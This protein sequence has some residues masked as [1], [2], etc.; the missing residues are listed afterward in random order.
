[1]TIRLLK[2]AAF[3][4]VA[5]AAMAP[6]VDDK[7]PTPE[8]L[9]KNAFGASFAGLTKGSAEMRMV[10]T[11]GNTV[12]DRTISFK[13]MREGKLLRYLVTFDSPPDERGTA[14][15]VREK[16]KDFPEQYIWLPATKTLTQAT[17]G[18]A[19]G[20]FFGSDFINADLEP[21]PEGKNDKV[22]LTRL[23][24]R[25]VGQ[26]IEVSYLEAGQKKV[27][28]I[29]SDQK[30]YVLRVAISDPQSPYSRIEAVILAKEMLAAQVDF[31]DPKGNPL[32]TMKVRKLSD[33]EGSLVPVDFVMQSAAGSKTEITVSKIKPN[34]T[35]DKEEFTKEALRR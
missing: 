23:P 8:A 16:E 4:C 21:Y 20:S 10:I 27:R 15:L 7:G 14:F 26:E 19:V 24:D 32:K 12:I 28:K 2:A 34:A 35:F 17:A 33:V 18:K 13:S 22:K 30:S 11:K 31:F 3:F 29:T 25:T 1:M 5:L 9:A 6:T